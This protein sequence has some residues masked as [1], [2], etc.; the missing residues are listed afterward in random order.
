MTDGAGTMNRALKRKLAHYHPSKQ[1]ACAV[2]VRVH[3]AKVSPEFNI[4]SPTE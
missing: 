1:D 2:Q 3:G 4:Q